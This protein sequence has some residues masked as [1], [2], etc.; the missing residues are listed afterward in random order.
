MTV[1]YSNRIAAAAHEM[2]ANMRRKNFVQTKYGFLTDDIDIMTA[3]YQPTKSTNEKTIARHDNAIFE[4]KNIRL[5]ITIMRRKKYLPHKVQP[6]NQSID[7][8]PDHRSLAI[9]PQRVYRHWR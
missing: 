4:I 5:I 1:H 8:M 2:L 9:N 7:V 3:Q 6:I